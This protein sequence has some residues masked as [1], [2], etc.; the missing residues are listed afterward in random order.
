LPGYVRAHEH[1]KKMQAAGRNSRHRRKRRRRS[2][3]TKAE[4]EIADDENKARDKD[5]EASVG[6]VVLLAV[7]IVLVL[8]LSYIMGQIKTE[9][10]F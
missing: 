5:H 9:T 6:L 2:L 7:G 1:R 3:F 8:L 4:Q 10:P